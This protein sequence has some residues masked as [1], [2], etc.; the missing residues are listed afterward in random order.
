MSEVRLEIECEKTVWAALS[1]LAFHAK[2]VHEEDKLNVT[3][4]LD[5]DQRVG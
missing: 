1:H 5:S 3:F 4:C 2:P